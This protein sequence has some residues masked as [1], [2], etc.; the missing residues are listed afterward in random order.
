M[1][2][3][4]PA[5][6]SPAVPAAPPAPTPAPGPLRGANS[7]PSALQ[8]ARELPWWTWVIVV[9]VAAGG[10]WYLTRPAD[11]TGDWESQA[12]VILTEHGYSP[13]AINSALDHYLRGGGMSS[14]DVAII[15]VAIR[16]LGLPPSAVGG[17]SDSHTVPTLPPGTQGP[18]TQG[19]G[20]TGTA[21]D[22][23]GYWYVTTFP[24]GW[25]ATFRGISLQFYGTTERATY[26][27]AQNPE[28]KVAT[29]WAQIPTGSRVRVPRSVNA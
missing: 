29:P 6:G 22:H 19:G 23:T 25:S 12:R 20:G 27:M 16:Q 15:A 17:T 21:G 11:P 5:A 14:Q 1:T 10:Y 4:S 8:R 28:V 18:P 24:V 2:S 9:G 7:V 13:D 26:L 3:P